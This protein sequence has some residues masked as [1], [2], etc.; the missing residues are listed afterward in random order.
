MK[1]INGISLSALTNGAHIEFLN[2]ITALAKADE[3]VKTKLAK[4][5]DTLTAA[6]A[7]E[8]ADFKTSTKS[9]KT[10]ELAEAD[11]ERDK[12]YSALK[13]AAQGFLDSPL[14]EV[15]AAAKAVCQVIKDYGID[16]RTQIDQETAELDSITKDFKEKYSAEITALGLTAYVTAIVEQNE[17]VRE[18]AAERMA[19][20]EGVVLGAMKKDCAASDEQYRLLAKLANAYAFIEGDAELGG[21]IDQVNLEIKHYKEQAIGGKTASADGGGTTGDEPQA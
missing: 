9:L 15:A 5:L 10:D 19:E 2:R 13:K 1:E 4:Y 7:Q 6:L 16:T 11:Q 21:F 20:K 14:E 3:A 8:D 18:L 17:K 12:Y